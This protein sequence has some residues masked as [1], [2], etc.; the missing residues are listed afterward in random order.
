MGLLQDVFNQDPFSAVTLTDEVNKMP[1][2]PDFIGSLNLFEEQGVSTVL[3]QVQ[4]SQGTIG[5]VQTAPRCAPGEHHVPSK[6]TART[7]SIPHLP[8]EDFIQVCELEGI[9]AGRS[10]ALTLQS[11]QSVVS[12]R[13]AAMSASL[14]AT[15][16][17][18][19]LGAINGLILDAD[20]SVIYDLY[21][22]FGVTALPTVQLDF[23]ALINGNLKQKLSQTMREQS[24]ELQSATA[25]RYV[26]LAGDDLYDGFVKSAETQRAY[27]RWQD[28]QHLRDGG[29]A[30]ESFSYAGIEIVNYRA[31]V[32]GQDFI[33]PEKGRL[34]P[35]GVPGLFRKYYAPADRMSYLATMGLPRYAF[36]YPD[37]RDR[38]V[39]LHQQMNV[40]C[41]NTQP[42][43]VREFE[44]V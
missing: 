8:K 41:L 35:I 13:M 12:Q 43:A 18:H 29:L 9:L 15:E 4:E 19:M 2:V 17:W 1:F 34:I 10:D 36:T 39:E 44:V 7:F 26:L 33:A 30:Y 31:Y 6:R 22:E 14:D 38:Y 32:N 37:E 5:L 16:E 25:R 27:D 11:L 42:R 40:L 21:S 24:K 3:I 28:G 20:G 23:A